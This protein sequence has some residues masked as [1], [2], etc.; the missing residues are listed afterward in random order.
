MNEE[1]RNN[2]VI[3]DENTDDCFDIRKALICGG[4][5]VVLGGAGFL[6]KKLYDKRKA[7]KEEKKEEPVN[8][9]KIEVEVI[10]EEAK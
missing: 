1:Y 2:E 3:E 10:E 4:V 5:A 7:R 9:E 8:P 6:I